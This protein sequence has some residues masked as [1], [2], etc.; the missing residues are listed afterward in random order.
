MSS[1]LI[2]LISVVGVI[3]LLMLCTCDTLV[4]PRTEDFVREAHFSPFIFVNIQRHLIVLT[5][6]CLLTA[7]LLGN[8]RV[9][10]VQ[11]SKRKYC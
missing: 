5:K 1:I 10:T 9:K 6:N 3:I 8:I 11:W 2:Y 4:F 7:S